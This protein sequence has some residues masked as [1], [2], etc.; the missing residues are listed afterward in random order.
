MA[1]R[2][3]RRVQIREIADTAAKLAEKSTRWGIFQGPDLCERSAAS[4]FNVGNAMPELQADGLVERRKAIE[5][6]CERWNRHYLT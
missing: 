6:S 5:L 4:C 3:S 2:P 1:K